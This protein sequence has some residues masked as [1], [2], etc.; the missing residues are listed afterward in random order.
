MLCPIHCHLLGISFAGLS[1]DFFSTI[2]LNGLGIQTISFIETQ[3]SLDSRRSSG[4]FG[5][6][7]DLGD[8]F[9]IYM[10]SIWYD[11]LMLVW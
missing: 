5:Y 9:W 11:K 1:F 8:H 6:H 10:K 3:S 4:S 2:R 7:S